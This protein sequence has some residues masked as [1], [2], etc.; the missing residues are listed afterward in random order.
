MRQTW[1]WGAVAAWALASGPVLAADPNELKNAIKALD[2]GDIKSA[3]PI[4]QNYAL[5]GAIA[6]QNELGWLY[7][8][9]HGVPVDYREAVKW[10][11]L[12]A[13]QGGPSD[14][15][16]LGRMYEQGLGVPKN[17]VEAEKWFGLSALQGFA[18][19]QFDLAYLH[20]RGLGTVPPFAETVALYKKAADQGLAAAQYQYALCARNGHVP[21][22]KAVGADYLGRAADQGYGPALD[23]LG[24]DQELGRGV[25]QNH[26]IAFQYYQRGAA[27]GDGNAMTHLAALYESGRGVPKN[28]PEAIRW[29]RAAVDRNIPEAAYRLGLIDEYGL[30]DGKPNPAEGFK[31][32][33]T[34]ADAGDLADAQNHLGE[35]YAAG[36]GVAMD[37]TEGA[38]W[39]RRA[40]A[41]NSAAAMANLALAYKNGLGVPVDPTEA[42]RWQDQA[43][44]N[45]YVAPGSAP[46]AVPTPLSNDLSS[47]FGATGI[48][49]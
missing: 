46:T 28:Y 11:R 8:T 23:L 42:R 47:I 19:G 31:W 25:P 9:G 16:N 30:A 27:A 1:L 38:R 36:R 48:K 15:T 22:G 7:E 37:K 21:D 18:Q 40:A 14:Q 24:R 26:L 32:V 4:V 3:L 12:S 41:Q 10:Y 20:D 5:N 49:P 39:F 35:M 33:R 45:G 2:A 6:A 44:A 34:A 13:L 29:Y 17:Y 43:V